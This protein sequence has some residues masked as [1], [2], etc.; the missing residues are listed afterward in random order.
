MGGGWGKGKVRKRGREKT[1][2]VS[3]EE[4]EDKILKS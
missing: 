2:K 1:E 3:T 4:N